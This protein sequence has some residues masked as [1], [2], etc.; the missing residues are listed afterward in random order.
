MCG[1]C[2]YLPAPGFR[3]VTPE[4]LS[5][6]NAR[7][8]RRGPDGAGAHIAPEIGLAMRR[9]AIIDIAGGQQ[10][11]ANEDRTVV[12]VANGEIYNYRELRAELRD[13]GHV[14][15]TQSDTEVLVHAYETWG[16][17][18]LTR[19]IGMFALAVW[20]A[21][22]ERLL[23]A[24][25]RMGEKPL[26]W[27]ASPQGLL[28]G[29][30]LASVLAAPWVGRQVNPA[31]LHH[32][33][34]LQFIPDPLSVYDGIQRLPSAH[35]LVAGP[36]GPPEVSRWW[37]PTF[38]PKVQITEQEAI[39]TGT[40][41]LRRVVERQLVADVPLGAY[42]SG[43]I[44]SGTI[45]S[46]MAELQPE[47]VK[48][49]TIAF[50]QPG[51]DE[52]KP[53]AAVARR[54][55]TMHHE[56]RFTA[57]DIPAA[58][59]AAV[60]ATG[61]P[62]ADPAILPLLILSQHARADVTVALCGD[63]GDETL[64]GYRRYAMDPLLA[65]YATA[66]R[67]LTQQ[68]APALL[69]RLPETT[70]LPEDRNPT[71]ALRRLAQ[72][73]ATPA[74]ASLLRWTSYFAPEAK[75]ALYTDSM[76][77]AV[78]GMETTDLLTRAYAGVDATGWLDRTLGADQAVYLA[79]GLLPKTDRATM[80]VA[81][82][83]RAPFLDLEWVEW[84]A[85]LPVRLKVRGLTTK[86]LL[87]RIAADRLPAEFVRRGKQGWSLPLGEWLRGDL[88]PWMLSWLQDR[89]V[90]DPWF[91]REAVAWLIEEHLSGRANHGK[92]LWALLVFSIWVGQHDAN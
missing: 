28:W 37:R 46:F 42:L 34:S 78:C 48:T 5:E 26:Y 80:A 50:D 18:A 67:W 52:S 54:F 29:S 53:A 1:I 90:L 82:E 58:T 83:A 4:L 39:E 86:W 33:L 38:A 55:G 13:R 79:G 15:R 14:F 68:A 51:F 65:R 7:L 8:E 57:A 43:G 23:L 17:D 11:I 12:V 47:P 63:G 10:P 87:R 77:E 75:Q 30:E 84:T 40:A 89:S 69:A 16:D 36:G 3:P 92:R 73:A 49:F 66:P 59:A 64:G 9:L 74:S 32:Y 85:R 31:A 45:V 24:R 88:R 76:R 22:R 91:R 71:T 81:L 70:G 41:L 60:A 25:D 19:F 56:V 62:L 61:E 72:F 6:M 44:D 35:K 20:D 2:G 21:R 27:H